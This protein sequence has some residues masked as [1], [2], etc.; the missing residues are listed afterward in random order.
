MTKQFSITRELDN[1]LANAK[2]G[3][4]WAYHTGKTPSFNTFTTGGI[5][6]ESFQWARR[7]EAA[8]LVHLAQRRLT[9]STTTESGDG[10]FEY[11]AIRAKQAGSGR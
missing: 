10:V 2:P 7:A 9:K 3:D 5:T 4:Q 6:G 1:W 8:G 11:L